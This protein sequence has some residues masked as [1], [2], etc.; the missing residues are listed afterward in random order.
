MPLVCAFAF[1][2]S[3]HEKTAELKKEIKFGNLRLLPVRINTDLAMFATAP[4]R[5]C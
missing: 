2:G 5:S 1:E 3:V 4:A